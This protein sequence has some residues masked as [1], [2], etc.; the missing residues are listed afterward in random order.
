MKNL[1]QK[2]EC[3]TLSPRRI[4]GLYCLFGI[5]WISFTSFLVTP[6]SEHL[7]YH[8][9]FELIK[10]IAYVFFTSWL[11][12]Q[13]CTSFL[14]QIEKGQRRYENYVAQSPTAIGV[15]NS[16]GEALDFNRAASTL[17]GYTREELLERSIFDLEANPDPDAA[18][19]VLAHIFA[20]GRYAFDSRMV[21]KDGS[22]AIVEIEAI[23][24]GGHALFYVQD[25]T[26]E[27]ANELKLTMLN[28]MLRAIR[29]VNQAIVDEKETHRLTQKI[30]EILVKDRDFDFAW[31]AL[32]DEGSGRLHHLSCAPSALDTDELRAFVT[33]GA[34]PDCLETE[35]RQDSLVVSLNPSEECSD[36]PVTVGLE[37]D[38]LIY[39][40][41]VCDK[42]EGHIALFV[43]Q[44]AAR[45]EE[46]LS[47]FR[48]VT[49]DLNHAL[50]SI[51][52]EHEKDQAMEDLVVATRK[53]EEANEAK[54]QFLSVISHEMR[55]P[56]NPIIGHC[57]LLLEETE[58]PDTRESLTQISTG[59]EQLLTLVEEI[60][61]YMNLQREQVDSNDHAM[62][63]LSCCQQVEASASP[64]SEETK[65]YFENGNE[66]LKPIPEDLEVF[67]IDTN[68]T[69]LLRNLVS[70]ACKYTKKGKIIFSYG[71]QSETDDY[72][73]CAFKVWDTGI[74]I[75]PK[76][77]ED[78]FN[79][80]TQADYSYTRKYEG[81][82]LGLATCRR[83]AEIA[84][85]SLEAESTPGAGSCFTYRCQFKR[86]DGKP[87][88]AKKRSMPTSDP[89]PAEAQHEA[90][91]HI[92]IVEDNPSNALITQKILQRLN[93]RTTVAENGQVAEDLCEHFLYD[94]ILMDLSMPVMNGYDA[95]KALRREDSKNQGT[96]IIA[97][98]AH[99]DDYS[100]N[101]SEETG[102]NGFLSKP[103]SV[104][105]L[106]EALE[107]HIKK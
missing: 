56:L 17:T 106:K 45:D 15:Y 79:P 76:K 13:L 105:A 82:G 48:E 43:S 19:K 78:L 61:F 22:Y 74:G 21:R 65:I 77:L 1:L 9:V 51:M 37:N 33:K 7:E 86:A 102:M 87:A 28:A 95:T 54:S 68:L 91:A 64:C 89:E 30:C 5:L 40:P 83:I 72:V 26:A 59:A 52:I 60:L 38:A 84:G 2:L 75:D 80:F 32:F 97:L 57:E 23:V 66:E 85:G 25:R 67:G 12:W 94:A 18:Q 4:A 24:D 103:V 3:T 63:I 96:P 31:I 27:K 34:F 88:S 50:H 11:L 104:G 8:F 99:I 93:Y 14:A 20:K 35:A 92:L 29:R 81:V 10:G 107:Q 44:A 47:L 36:L 16:N 41:L 42:Y 100:K 55:T 70:N 58:D 101:I 53:A 69:H 71:I 73:S 49:E 62:E 39:A 6:Q 98:S 90:N 46:E